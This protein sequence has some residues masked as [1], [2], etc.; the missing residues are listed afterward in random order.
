MKKLL[1]I[2]LALIMVFGM[3]VPAFAAE[4]VEVEDTPAEALGYEPREFLFQINAEEIGRVYKTKTMMYRDVDTYEVYGPVELI[5]HSDVVN[6][7]GLSFGSVHSDDI[8]SIAMGS[9]YV[10]YG[11]KP[12]PY[13]DYYRIVINE[14]GY[15][16]YGGMIGNLAARVNIILDV[17][18][19][20]PAYE[21]KS[22]S[23]VGS[24]RWSHDAIMEMVGQGLFN[25]MT[26]PD[27]NGIATF[28]PAETMT[29]SQFLIVMERVLWQ[30]DL[31]EYINSHEQGAYWYSRYYD[32]AVDRGLIAKE[33]FSINDMN[34]GITREEMALLVTRT[35]SGRGEFIPS[36]QGVSDK[37]A[38][39]N[40]V[41]YYYSGSVE[42]AYMMGIITGMDDI[43]TFAPQNK[44][45]R[46]QG[47]MV[48]YRIL[49]PGERKIPA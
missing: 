3:A 41:G 46:E 9:Q 45:T 27:K 37:I 8:Q 49:N 19:K 39:Y 6:G 11:G 47:A 42:V 28:A 2:V 33:E 21:L 25:G 48:V 12:E 32:F 5:I 7:N 23:D 36:T 14:P 38:D 40:K 13:G 26:D 43:G 29:V 30:D 35:L 31:T 10:E 20:A 24:S 17:K 44:L 34:R 1:S 22:F 15:Y 16:M 18:M 4:S